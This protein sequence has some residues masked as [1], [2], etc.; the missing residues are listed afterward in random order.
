MKK[1]LFAAVAVAVAVAAAA[2]LAHG[3]QARRRIFVLADESRPRLH[4]WDSADPSACFSIPGERPMWDLKR[5]G[6]MR[7]RAVCKNGFKVFDLRE[8]KV[9]DEFRHPS[10]DEVTAVCDMPDG[11]FVAS[12]NPRSGPDKGKVV[13]L[14]RFSAGRE[15]VA[16][17]RCE[18]FFYAR[19]LQWD[20]DGETLLLSWEKGF[21]RVRLPASGDTCAVLGD[22]RQPKGRNLFDVVPDV[23]GDGY[24]AGCGYR[25]GLVRFSADGKALSTWF[26]P[27]ANGCRSYFYAQTKQTPGGHVYMAHWTGHGA[28]DSTNGWQVVEF[29]GEG[30][31]V[32]HLHD[33]E[34]FGSIS[35]I[36]VLEP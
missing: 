5:V 23:S 27:E 22:F 3:G 14:R 30:R 24:V 11:G 9:V 21:A 7:Y 33:P 4:Y 2:V 16:T 10:L 31:D 29:D 25:G 32:W 36:D 26:V 15:P 18:G 35:G 1:I 19:S 28:G 13:L 17:Y 12:V 8:R 6:D 34:R 20:R